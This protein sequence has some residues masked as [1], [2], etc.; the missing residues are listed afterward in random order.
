MSET[1]SVGLFETVAPPTF[2]MCN[3]LF[4]FTSGTSNRR[5]T[6]S[7]RSFNSRRLID[8]VIETQ[9]P[10]DDVRRGPRGPWYWNVEQFLTLET[11]RAT[12]ILALGLQSDTRKRVHRFN[13]TPVSRGQPA[14]CEVSVRR[15][16]SHVV[17]AA[18]R[19]ALPH[20][21]WSSL[22][23]CFPWRW[24]A[25]NAC[26]PPVSK[27]L[28][29]FFKRQRIKGMIRWAKELSYRWFE[30]GYRDGFHRFSQLTFLSKVTRL[31]C[32]VGK[33]FCFASWVTCGSPPF[34]GNK[35]SSI[36]LFSQAGKSSMRARQSPA[37]HKLIKSFMWITLY[38]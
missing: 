32:F 1:L 21:A 24:S 29:C 3:L 34:P 31:T 19:P 38:H 23:V 16:A 37:R 36:C 26:L 15:E 20:G 30:G 5:E 14:A 18:L 12:L 11:R 2:Q 33:F 8:S 25:C 6:N 28:V 17:V 7:R 22:F 13:E 4:W 27:N 35:Y 9:L 10:V